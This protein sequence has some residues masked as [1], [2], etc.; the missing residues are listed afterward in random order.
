[1][2]VREFLNQDG[3]VFAVSWSGPVLPDLQQ[4][5]GPHFA[6][7]SSALAALAHPGLQRSVRVASSGLV[8]ESGGHM[9][10]YAGRAYLPARIP[11]GV[12]VAELRK[13]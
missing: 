3:A 11:S 2:R 8:V 9:R 6:E 4:L 7:Y 12:S 5:L 1:M 10:A 13:S